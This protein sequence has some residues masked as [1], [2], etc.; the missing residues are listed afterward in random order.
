MT[1]N[2]ELPEHLFSFRPPDKITKKRSFKKKKNWQNNFSLKRKSQKQNKKN[3]SLTF[4][5]SVWCMIVAFNPVFGL[6]KKASTVPVSGSRPCFS[7]YLSTLQLAHRKR[8]DWYFV[9]KSTKALSAHRCP[10]ILHV[11]GST[12]QW[13]CT[14]H[15][16]IPDSMRQIIPRYPLQIK[17]PSSIR[18]LN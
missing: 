12:F 4:W 9:P 3:K 18:I 2:A 8:F 16:L 10:W 17:C 5:N 1:V 7:V 13:L 15:S 11:A 14:P 6:T